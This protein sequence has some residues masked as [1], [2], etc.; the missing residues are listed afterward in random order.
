VTLP[1]KPYAPAFAIIGYFGNPQGPVASRFQV[2]PREGDCDPT[3]AAT[4][5]AGG[6]QVC[7]ADGS[8]RALSPGM[9]GDLWWAAVTP[10]G[11]ELLGSDW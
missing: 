9:S 7:L 3:R 8:V 1:I 6:I 11:G 5:H 2:Q 10:R 4:A